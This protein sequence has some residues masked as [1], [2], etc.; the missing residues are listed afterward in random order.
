MVQGSRNGP[1]RLELM[2][3]CMRHTFLIDYLTNFA[4]KITRRRAIR[5]LPYKNLSC[6]VLLTF[7]SDHAFMFR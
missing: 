3:W 4:L 6:F 2:Q 1:C 5:G 7:L